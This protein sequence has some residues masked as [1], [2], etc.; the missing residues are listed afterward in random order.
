[1]EGYVHSIETFG[2][3]DGPGVRFVIFLSGCGFRCQ[4]CH[5]PDT[6]KLHAGTRRTA[7]ELIAQAKKYRPYWGETGGITVSGGEPLLQIE[8][9]TELFQ[10]AK[11][12]GIHTALDTSG[13]PFTSQGGFFAAFEKLM[14]YTDLILLDLKQMD[15]AQHRRLTG[16]T[17]AN[18]KELARYLAEKKKPVWIRH[19]LVPGRTDSEEHLCQL[20]DFLDTLSNVERVEVLPY[21]TMGAYK[22]K[23]LGMVYPLEG[24]LPP[25][26]ESIKYARKVLGAR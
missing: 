26:Q 22:W 13:G 23:E 19:V 4:Y 8:F 12:E 5:N 14:Q 15:E 10:K 6:W 25:D 7:E 2:S 24:V 18:V 9:L 21:H 20:R 17:N 1:M 3:V 11:E 16:H